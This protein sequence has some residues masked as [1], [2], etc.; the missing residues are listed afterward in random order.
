MLWTLDG[1]RE[2]LFEVGSSVFCVAALPDGVHFVV[3]LACL[4]NEGPFGEGPNSGLG[5]GGGGTVLRTL[6]HHA[7]RDD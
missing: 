4:S 7:S 1:A 3:G 2:S 5:V 6:T